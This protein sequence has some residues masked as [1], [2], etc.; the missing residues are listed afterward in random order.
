MHDSCSAAAQ[1]VPHQDLWRLHQLGRTGI[2]SI[3]GC[4]SA[5]VILTR[6]TMSVKIQDTGPPRAAFCVYTN[7]AVAMPDSVPAHNAHHQSASCR[8]PSWYAHQP[9]CLCCGQLSRA[10][11][12][13][14]MRRPAVRAPCSDIASLMSYIDI[15]QGNSEGQPLLWLHFR[16]S[17][18]TCACLPNVSY[19][20]LP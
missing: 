17:V 16:S 19:E 11:S 10:D 1:L 20:G 2:R 5:K 13:Y 4:S 8:K 14:D 7:P 6:S 9:G 15:L 18:I 12:I 3:Q